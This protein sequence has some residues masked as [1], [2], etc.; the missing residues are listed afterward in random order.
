MSENIIKTGEVMRAYG[1][2]RDIKVQGNTAFISGSEKVLMSFDVSDPAQPLL[3][4]YAYLPDDLP[5][6]PYAAQ[7][8]GKLLRVG[9]YLYFCLDPSNVAVFDVGDPAAISYVT[10]IGG[11]NGIDGMKVQDA[12]RLYLTHSYDLKIW[13][14]ALPLSP[15]LLG[16]YTLPGGAIAMQVSGDHVFV[17]LYGGI[18]IGFQL[19]VLDVSDP[20][21]IILL[22]SQAH[23]SD[24]L[25][26]Y[27]DILYAVDLSSAIYILDVSNPQTPVLV[28][29]VPLPSNNMWQSIEW[30]IDDGWLYARCNPFIHDGRN[31]STYLRFDLANPLA[32]IQLDNFPGNYDYYACFDVENNRIYL[33]E[34]YNQIGI[35]APAN[36]NDIIKTGEIQRKSVGRSEIVNGFLYLNNGYILNTAQPTAQLGFF[37]NSVYMDSDNTAL[38]T[39]QNLSIRRWDLSQPMNPSISADLQIYPPDYFDGYK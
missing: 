6:S 11:L 29:S 7:C 18:S 28:G 22:S 10:S 34:N 2:A 4:S 15:Q 38:Y 32:P 24:N 17:N 26:L 19:Y 27:G 23:N 36:S 37:D 39:M 1:S 30:L 25:L 12:N 35:H 8:Y 33:T 16:S 9:G 5:F 14:L 21:N 13:D 3:L 31:H 20:Q